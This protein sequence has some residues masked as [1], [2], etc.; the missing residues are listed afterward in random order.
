MSAA[1]VHELNPVPLHHYDDGQNQPESSVGDQQRLQI[2]LAIVAR[3]NRRRQG[4]V[5]RRHEHGDHRPIHQRVHLAPG[6]V[7]RDKGQRHRRRGFSAD[8]DIPRAKGAVELVLPELPVRQDV[9]HLHDVVRL[10]QRHRVPRHLRQQVREL[11]DVE[12]R[13]A[14]CVKLVE[15]RL[16]LIWQALV[17]VPSLHSHQQLLLIDLLVQIPI[18]HLDDPPDLLFRGPHASLDLLEERRHLIEVEKPGAVEIE[19]VEVL[20]DLDLRHIERISGPVSVRRRTP[21]VGRARAQ[22][23]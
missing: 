18:G 7:V 5:C 22:V 2:D 14:V 19:T 20:M 23:P 4:Q 3:T 8:A 16:E 13:V 15:H 9:R 10:S 1:E 17:A 21:P 6:P 11:A 12:V